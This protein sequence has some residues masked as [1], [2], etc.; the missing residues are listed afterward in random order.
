MLHYGY[1]GFLFC[2]AFLTHLYIKY[3]G[4]GFGG[5]SNQGSGGFSSFSGSGGA[6]PP[7]LLTQMRK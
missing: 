1:D 2:Y 3:E 5:F 7:N 6:A 4:G